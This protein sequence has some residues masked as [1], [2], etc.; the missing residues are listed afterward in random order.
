MISTLLTL[1]LSLYYYYYYYY[2]PSDLRPELGYYGRPEAL[3]PYLDRF[4]SQA[5]VFHRA[6]AQAVTC[7]PSRNSIMSG[8]RPDSATTWAFESTYPSTWVSWPEFFK[9]NGFETSQVGKIHHWFSTHPQSW[10]NLEPSRDYVTRTSREGWLSMG[11]ASPLPPPHG[12]G[13]LGAFEW[14]PPPS[15]R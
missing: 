7:N 5:L 3:T 13:P 4:A 11:T 6:Y 2:Y 1:S 12:Q 9:L 15:N 10:T 8:R 14:P